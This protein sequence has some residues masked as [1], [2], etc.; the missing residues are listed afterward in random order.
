M[1]DIP[2]A[3]WAVSLALTASLLLCASLAQEAPTTDDTAFD[4]EPPLLVKPWEQ[5][6][7][8]LEANAP[9]ARPDPVKLAQQFENAKKSAA[10]AARLVKNGILSKVEAELRGL[11]VVRVE[12]ELAHAQMI[13]AQEQVTAQKA[14]LAAGQATQSEVDAATATLTQ[15]TAAAQT[16]EQAYHK[17][18]LDSA[19]LNLRRQRQLL[20][21]G[22]AAKSDAA[23]A[24]ARLARLQQD[25]AGSP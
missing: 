1:S 6:A 12:S 9:G 16:A 14:R 3:K 8:D 24:E 15:A 7:D 10:A 23:R 4:V 19:E 18:E 21:L 13:A 22:S 25:N 11:H 17:A 2:P 20:A 5:E